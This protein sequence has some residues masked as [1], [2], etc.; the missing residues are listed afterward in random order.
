[1]TMFTPLGIVWSPL[2]PTLCRLSSFSF[3][4][5][6]PATSSYRFL[7]SGSLN[8]GVLPVFIADSAPSGDFDNSGDD[9]T[10]R[11]PPA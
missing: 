8:V 7:A 11:G 10:L 9:G 5:S 6:L 3:S 4:W 1:L 2:P